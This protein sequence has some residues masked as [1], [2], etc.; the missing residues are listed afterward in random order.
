M[1]SE[2]TNKL[3]TTITNQ[4][5]YN[6][7]QVVLGTILF[8]SEAIHLAGG[9]IKPE[10]FNHTVHQDIYSVMLTLYIKS[11]PIDLITMAKACLEAGISD[12]IGGPTYL[13]E[14]TLQVG[15]SANFEFHLKILIQNWIGR[16]ILMLCEQGK[17]DA[18]VAS[19]DPLELLSNLSSKLVQLSDEVVKSDTRSLVSIGQSLLLAIEKKQ[20]GESYLPLFNLPSFDKAIDGA[21][22]GDLIIIGGRPGMGKSSLINNLLKASFENGTPTYMNSL[23][24]TSE[25]TLARLI[26]ARVNIDGRKIKRGALSKDEYELVSNELQNITNSSTLIIDGHTGG[27]VLDFRTRIIRFKRTH[28]IKIAVLD[29]IGLLENVSQKHTNLEK[30][31]HATKLLRRT[32]KELKITI[33][34]LSQ[35]NRAVENRPDRKPNISD[36]RDSGSLEQDAKKVILLYRPEYYNIFEDNEGNSLKKMGVLILAKNTNGIVGE[37]PLCFEAITTQFKD[38]EVENFLEP[39]DETENDDTPF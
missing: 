10:M 8:D 6:L 33:V 17:M 29:R 18:T 1:K 35:L 39:G 21:E 9:M 37:Y 13:S 15:S 31:S 3:S 27:S 28:D 22:E 20:S 5:Y 23:E 16:E 7:E 25:E 38:I 2:L 12:R 30:L 19:V 11:I 4:A 36:L 14:L 26:S 24:M 32:A 34:I